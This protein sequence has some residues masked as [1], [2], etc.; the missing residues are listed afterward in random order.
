MDS[1][2]PA[3]PWPAGPRVQVQVEVQPGTPQV[4]PLPGVGSARSG[5]ELACVPLQI[6]FWG[7]Q[8]SIQQGRKKRKWRWR[9]AGCQACAPLTVSPAKQPLH[10]PPSSWGGQSVIFLLFS[11]LCRSILLSFRLRC[12][13]GPPLSLVLVALRKHWPHQS[14]DT[15][16]PSRRSLICKL[17][18]H[19]SIQPVFIGFQSLCQTLGIEL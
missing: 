17:S 14:L 11:G 5:L 2:G 15:N 12:G 18:T 19:P 10:G 3:L 1:S 9:G 6:L 7:L 4:S 13:P 8:P 16:H